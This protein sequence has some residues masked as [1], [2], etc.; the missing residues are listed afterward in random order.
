MRGY[1]HKLFI[2]VQESTCNIEGIKNPSNKVEFDV[3]L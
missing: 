3:R 2:G 1:F